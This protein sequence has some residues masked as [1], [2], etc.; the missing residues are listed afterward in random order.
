MVIVYQALA[1]GAVPIGY[2]SIIDKNVRCISH[3]TY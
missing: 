1:M 3:S 2:D